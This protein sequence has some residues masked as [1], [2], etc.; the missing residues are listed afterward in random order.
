ME[1][2]LDGC[3]VKPQIPPVKD[4][5]NNTATDTGEND[6]AGEM[7]TI[8]GDMVGDDFDEDN[9]MVNTA[10]RKFEDSE[11]LAEELERAEAKLRDA[12]GVN[13]QMRASLESYVPD[14]DEVL[15]L[16]RTY[17][18]EPSMVNYDATLAWVG[19]RQDITRTESI[20]RGAHFIFLALHW[21]KKYGLEIEGEGSLSKALDDIKRQE[22]KIA[23]LGAVT[24][25]AAIHQSAAYSFISTFGVDPETIDIQMHDVW[26]SAVRRR[27]ILE[28]LVTPVVGTTVN[29]LTIALDRDEKVREEFEEYQERVEDILKQTLKALESLS[30]GVELVPDLSS[31]EGGIEA[32]V[33][34]TNAFTLMLAQEGSG[35]DI[36]M[37]FVDGVLKSGE[38]VVELL[39]DDFEEKLMSIR[40]TFSRSYNLDDVT[41]GSGIVVEN[42]EAVMRSISESNS[43][44]SSLLDALRVILATHNSL[45]HTA[46]AKN[47]LLAAYCMFLECLV[48]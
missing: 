41:G 20:K 48:D 29:A 5:S 19:D 21:I 34:Q 31:F 16:A 33:K 44:L 47:N 37:S 25:D 17:T 38:K 42:P 11:V 26:S 36:E 28:Q 32:L 12:Q 9:K 8:F 1:D 2:V 46:T 14:E 18:A 40:E 30:E 10:H 27:R 39:D 13:Q 24:F 45:L 43:V 6:F 22:S 35:Y 3:I 23:D 15:P 7:K 4:V